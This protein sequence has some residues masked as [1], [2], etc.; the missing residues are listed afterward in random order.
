[1][2]GFIDVDFIQ[3]GSEEFT[4]VEL[5]SRTYETAGCETVDVDRCIYY[6]ED[7]DLFYSETCA[8][9]GFV[10]TVPPQDPDYYSSPVSS[11]PE[12]SPSSDSPSSNSPSSDSD[13]SDD[14]RNSSSSKSDAS[15][16]QLSALA[17]LA[18]ALLS[19]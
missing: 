1:M 2:E 8:G 19:I 10:V 3:Y 11:S 5:L 4:A 13:S 15:I 6:A 16:L 14:E 9:A 12:G 18:L 7:C 17:A